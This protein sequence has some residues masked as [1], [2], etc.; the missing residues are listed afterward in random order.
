MAEERPHPLTAS[1]LERHVAV[2]QVLALYQNTKTKYGTQLPPAFLDVLV[3]NLYLKGLCRK[4]DTFAK[5][6]EVIESFGYRILVNPQESEEYKKA[7][8]SLQ[9]IK[10][11]LH[12]LNDVLYPIELTSMSGRRSNLMEWLAT[13][14]ARF[15]ALSCSYGTLDRK[16]VD[17]AC[18]LIGELLLELMKGPA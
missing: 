8:F 4:P 12:F 15:A 6:Q 18:V 11:H 16:G 3:S 7:L 14:K 10:N 17:D 9:E 2:D 13:N 5:L 1:E